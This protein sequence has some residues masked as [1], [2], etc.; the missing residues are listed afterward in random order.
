MPTHNPRTVPIGLAVSEMWVGRLL[1]NEK[2]HTYYWLTG[3]KKTLRKRKQ[4][5]TPNSNN[6]KVKKNVKI[7]EKDKNTRNEK[8]SKLR[9]KT[10]CTTKNR[11]QTPTKR[12]TSKTLKP[13]NRV[14]AIR[15][16]IKPKEKNKSKKRPGLK[17][18]PLV[19]GSAKN[20]GNQLSERSSCSVCGKSIKK[21]GFSRHLKIHT[22]RAR[23][24]LCLKPYV[25]LNSS[26]LPILWYCIL[27]F[28]KVT[29]HACH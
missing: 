16:G 21:D 25:I 5:K 27:I 8:Q 17:L 9:E 12:T 7:L 24:V 3:G 18:L 19:K 29:L 13:R 26:H 15:A 22:K 6:L 23:F 4:A 11:T 2:P 1:V 10:S 14:K 28:F 20:T